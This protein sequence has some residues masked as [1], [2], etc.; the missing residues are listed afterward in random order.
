MPE[1]MAYYSFFLSVFA[2]IIAVGV[3][4]YT[5]RKNWKQEDE[6]Y[7]DV[8]IGSHRYKG[9]GEQ[10]PQKKDP[11]EENIQRVREIEEREIQGDCIKDVPKEEATPSQALLKEVQQ[12]PTSIIKEG[13]SEPTISEVVATVV[14]YATAVDERDN[15]TFILVEKTPQKGKTI[16]KFTEIQKGKC[17]FEVYEGAYSLVLKESEY[18]NGACSLDR[19][20]D[21]KVLTTQKGIAE[22]TVEGKWVVKF[23]AKVKFE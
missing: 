23:P 4:I 1:Q 11:G 6:T 16:F 2:L 15:K 21:S 14:L 8:S 10:N 17:E 18:L 7:S 13:N 19:I 22:Y 9:N 20:G 3:L 12:I 5:I